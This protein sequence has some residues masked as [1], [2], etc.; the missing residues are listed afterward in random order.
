LAQVCIK[1]GGLLEHGVHA[2]HL[3]SPTLLP[4]SAKHTAWHT[5][6]TTLY[7]ALHAA[8]VSLSVGQSTQWSTA[9]AW[10]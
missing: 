9:Q 3:G 2:G 7:P 10:H 6:S 1:T 5:L 8:H 4:K